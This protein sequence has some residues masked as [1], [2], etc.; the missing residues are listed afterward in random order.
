LLY[1]I[2]RDIVSKMASF[3]VYLAKIQSKIISLIPD[4]VKLLLGKALIYRICIFKLIT[5]R[6]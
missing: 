2:R 5:L 1:L 3:K 4:E 6:G